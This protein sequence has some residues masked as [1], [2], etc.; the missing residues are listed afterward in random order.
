M[1][2]P[3]THLPGRPLAGRPGV[4]YLRL[5]DEVMKL[6]VIGPTEKDKLIDLRRNAEKNPYSLDMLHDLEA[7]KIPPMGSIEGFYCYIPDGFRAV[8]SINQHPGGWCRHLSVSVKEK[9]LIP[10]LPALW[11]ICN[12]LGY[13]TNLLENPNGV[14]YYYLEDLYDGGQAINVVEK[15]RN[16]TPPHLAGLN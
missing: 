5:K 8:F 9:D 13:E 1:N 3:G 12:E 6:L 16:N 14:Y 15:I 2:T 7:G 4:I 11:A 10:P